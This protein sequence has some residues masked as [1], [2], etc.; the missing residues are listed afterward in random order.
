MFVFPSL[1][2]I[3]VVYKLRKINVASFV[4]IL[5]KKDF[6]DVLV[7]VYIEVFFDNPRWGVW[8]NITL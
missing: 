1:D 7:I 4:I 5:R 6:I 3:E 2:S 8:Y